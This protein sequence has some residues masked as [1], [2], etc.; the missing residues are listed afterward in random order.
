MRSAKNLVILIA[1][2]TAS[3]SLIAAGSGAL[4]AGASGSGVTYYGCLKAGKLSNVGTLPVTCKSGFTP[5]SWDST[6]PQG[7]PGNDG[8]PGAP[9][10]DGAPGSPGAPG[11]DG[12]PGP[13]GVSD[14]WTG[15]GTQSL[16]CLSCGRP[17]AVTSVN[18]PIG[19]Y[20]VT[21][22][23]NVQDNSTVAMASVPCFVGLY[24]QFGNAISLDN[25]LQTGKIAS[26][27]QANVTETTT[28]SLGAAATA[29]LFC[30]GQ[31][32]LLVATG[33]MTAAAVTTLH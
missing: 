32:G 20:L 19:N 17:F 5:A 7:P 8:A 29:G 14:V 9:G 3:V 10:A 11:A 4:S 27:D 16:S 26:G 23:V 30:Y 31:F 33:S 25:S 6:G 13:A 2:V 28:F 18:L 12:A 24:D 15:H 22:H 21:A 1:A